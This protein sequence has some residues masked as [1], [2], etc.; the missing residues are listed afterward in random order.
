MFVYTCV[1]SLK[2]TP[3]P[4][5]NNLE[6]NS[7][8]VVLCKAD[9]Q[10][11]PTVSWKKE[12]STFLPFHVTDNNGVL[13]FDSV[14]YTDAGVYTCTASSSQGVITATIILSVVSKYLAY[15]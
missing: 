2:F 3:K 14:Q 12:N 1:E 11:Q 5:N 7:K 4:S 9:G 15:I 13:T 8:S 6:Y 10:P